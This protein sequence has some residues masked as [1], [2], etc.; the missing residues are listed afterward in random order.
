[1]IN[2]IVL[3]HSN[4]QHVNNLLVNDCIKDCFKYTIFIYSSEIHDNGEFLSFMFEKHFYV[5]S[6]NS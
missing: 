1:M 2:V 5:S 6:V 4:N 3:C